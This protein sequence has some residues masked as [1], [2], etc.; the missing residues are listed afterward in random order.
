MIPISAVDVA[1]WCRETPNML[2][3]VAAAAFRNRLQH[4]ALARCAIL[5]G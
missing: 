4:L 2:Q 5:V 3:I 1:W